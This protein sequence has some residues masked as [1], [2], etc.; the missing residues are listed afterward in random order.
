MSAADPRLK[1]LRIQT[2]VVKRCG[3]EKLSYRKEANQQKEKLEKM[4]KEGKDDM[5][6]KKMNEQIQESLMMIPDCH[7]KLEKAV[8]ELKTLLDELETEGRTEASKE[9]ED[10]STQPKEISEAKSALKDSEDYLKAD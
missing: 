4:K 1:K 8:K 7:R 9:S 6:I 10:S 2:G 3:K 5:E